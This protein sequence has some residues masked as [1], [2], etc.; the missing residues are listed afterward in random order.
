MSPY[1]DPDTQAFVDA[2]AKSGGPPLQELSA[3][4]A[5]E[6]FENLQ[7]HTPSTDVM[8][9]EIDVTV[10][11]DN[12]KSFLYKPTSAKGDLPLIFYFHGGGWILGSP[13]IHDSLVRD[14]VRQTGC[15]IVFPYYTPAPEAKF[16][17][18]FE[19]AYG[20]VEYF[21]KNGSKYGLLT[22]KVA[23]AGDSVGGEYI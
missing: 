23:F 20:C 9:Q 17:H 18:Q 21:V 3:A 7:K 15:A 13:T 2:G 14:L 8:Q 1:L 16:P 22:D 12:V 11:S 19:E 10:G 5:R 6:M 4:E